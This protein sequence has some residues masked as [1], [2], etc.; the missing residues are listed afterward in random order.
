MAAASYNPGTPTLATLAADGTWQMPSWRGEP[1]TYRV[2]LAAGTCSCKAFAYGNGKACKHLAE[3][4][5]QAEFAR[6][7]ETARRLADGDLDRL[8]RKYVERGNPIIAGALMVARQERR[9]AA[10]RDAELR[11]VFA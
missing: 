3:V 6:R 9:Q 2:D 10:R 5:R 8:T 4:A 7:L 11:Q 1:E